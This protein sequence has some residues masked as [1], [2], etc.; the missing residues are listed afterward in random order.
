MLEFSKKGTDLSMSSDKQ[1][2]KRHIDPLLTFLWK[3]RKLTGSK[4][5]TGTFYES[6]IIS[7]IKAENITLSW[8]RAIT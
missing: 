1:T 6:V 2:S 8:S 4:A 3:G 5:T 7:Q